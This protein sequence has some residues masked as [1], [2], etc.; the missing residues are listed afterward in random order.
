MRSPLPEPSRRVWAGLAA[1]HLLQAL[2]TAHDPPDNREKSK[3]HAD[4]DNQ[5][6]QADQPVEKADPEG[7]DLESIVA[8][9]PFRRVGTVDISDD[10]ADEASDPDDQAGQIENIDDL[11]GAAFS[12]IAA[13][14]SRVDLRRAL[15]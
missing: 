13:G 11:R 3:E 12:R 8:L 9:D 4:H 14:D 15:T 2:G 10:H 1:R 5:G 7:A 6:D